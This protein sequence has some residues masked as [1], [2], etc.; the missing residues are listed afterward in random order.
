LYAVQQHKA[1]SVAQQLNIP[2]AEVYV[3]KSRITKMMREEI[4]RLE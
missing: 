1:K 4:A 3:A 2:I